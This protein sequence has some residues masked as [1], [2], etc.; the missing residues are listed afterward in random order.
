MERQKRWL[1]IP[2]RQYQQTK[3]TQPS[4]HLQ[5][6]NW[7]LPSTKAY[8]KTSSRRYSFMPV[9][10]DALPHPAELPKPGRGPPDV[11]AYRYSV[12][13]QAMGH[14]RGP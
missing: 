3:Q 13:K 5:A 6:Q 14:Q 12:Q 8:E 1:Q 11:L 4:Y 7:T 9:W 10:T 2:K